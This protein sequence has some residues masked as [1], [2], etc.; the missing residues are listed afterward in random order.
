MLIHALL[1]AGE[2]VRAV[3]FDGIWLDI[4]RPADYEEAQKTFA[5][6]AS[7]LLPE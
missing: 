2:P 3:P 1:K 6:L 7:R 5:A 4:G